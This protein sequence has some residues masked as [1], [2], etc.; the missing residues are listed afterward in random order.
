MGVSLKEDCKM[1]YFSK[2]ENRNVNQFLPGGWYQWKG[3][4]KWKGCR[5]VNMVLMYEYGKMRSVE[6]ILRLGKGG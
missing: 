1:F 6:T 5:R 3:E 4:D 2:T